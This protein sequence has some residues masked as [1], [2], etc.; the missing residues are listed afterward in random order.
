MKKIK[1]SLILLLLIGKCTL[2]A[3]EFIPTIIELGAYKLSGDVRFYYPDNLWDYINGAAVVFNAYDFQKLSLFRIIS[4]DSKEVKVEI[5][6]MNKHLNAY[7]I[8][9]TEKIQGIKSANIGINSFLEAENLFFWQDKYYV[10]IMAYEPDEDFLLN[11][12]KIVSAKLPNTKPFPEEFSLFPEADRII[13][14]ET[15]LRKE[16]FG[17]E[18]LVNGF[19]I[20]Y[21]SKTEYSIYLLALENE[22]LCDSVFNKYFDF[23]QNLKK[24]KKQNLNLGECSYQTS[25]AYYGTMSVIKIKNY[26]LVITGIKEKALVTKLFTEVNRKIVE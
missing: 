19:R 22:T 7:G 15:Y 18:Y 24:V 12:A 4:P 2:H 1:Y 10:K 8:Y 17:Q 26:M 23:Q 9:S 14:S 21:S 25:D 6:N 5:Y 16:I 13:G 3:Q 11:I 20:N